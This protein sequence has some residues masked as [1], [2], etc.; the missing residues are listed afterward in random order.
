MFIHTQV[1]STKSQCINKCMFHFFLPWR[2]TLIGIVQWCEK[3]GTYWLYLLSYIRSY[4]SKNQLLFFTYF[5]GNPKRFSESRMIFMQPHGLH[6]YIWH[7]VNGNEIIFDI[8][9]RV[10][11][12]NIC[13]KK[14]QTRICKTPSNIYDGSFCENN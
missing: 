12:K 4:L 9:F 6:A 11:P 10:T 5:F 7:E 1:S 14:L 13:M 3:V 2:N 8:F